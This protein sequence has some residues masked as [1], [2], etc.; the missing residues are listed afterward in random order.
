MA[1]LKK[2]V[3]V[4]LILMAGSTFLSRSMSMND[5]VGQDLV[6][7]HNYQPKQIISGDCEFTEEDETET[8]VYPALESLQRDFR[9]K[10]D[11]TLCHQLLDCRLRKQISP[12]HYTNLPPPLL[13]VF[14]YS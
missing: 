7:F 3:I 13:Q 9:A 10:K 12:H 8:D 1:K 2:L 4:L 5:R 11:F 14:R 6:A